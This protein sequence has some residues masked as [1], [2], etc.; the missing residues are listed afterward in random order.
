MAV[1]ER[2]ESGVLLTNEGEGHTI[3]FQG[4]P[5]VD[6]VAIDHLLDLVVPPDG[7]RC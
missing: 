5:C 6:R 2:L 4:S 3:V 7:D 1:A